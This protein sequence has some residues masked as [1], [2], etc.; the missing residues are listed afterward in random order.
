MSHRCRSESLEPPPRFGPASVRTRASKPS[1]FEWTLSLQ[2]ARLI[3]ANQA[4]AGASQPAPSAAGRR[5][6][7][8]G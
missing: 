5:P 8:D 1:R 7:A 3:P 6:G 4:A 2:S